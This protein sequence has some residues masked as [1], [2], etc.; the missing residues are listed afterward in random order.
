MIFDKLPSPAQLRDKMPKL[1]AAP[2]RFLPETVINTPL[3][4]ALN[5]TFKKPIA[6][7][8]FDVLTRRC[9]KFIVH[10]L[11]LKFYLSFDGER[12]IASGPRPSDVQIG[13][14]SRAFIKL[15]T[16]HEDPDTLFFQRRLMVQGD[17][18]LGLAVKNLL[19]ALDF[20]ELPFMVRGLLKLLTPHAN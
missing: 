12:L 9:V 20:S 13:G 10:D 4:I 19:D 1:L 6:A 3:T 5:Q 17:T 14:D 15:A 11:Q 2:V 18:D 16:R 8:D 7:G